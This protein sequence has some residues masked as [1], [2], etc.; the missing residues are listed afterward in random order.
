MKNNLK[1]YGKVYSNGQ[2]YKERRTTDQRIEQD[3]KEQNSKPI[4]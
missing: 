3:K 1:G 2:T 4:R